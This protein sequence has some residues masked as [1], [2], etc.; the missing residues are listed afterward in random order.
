[1]PNLLAN[2][3]L[4]TAVAGAVGL[5]V[6]PATIVILT[7]Q[8]LRTRTAF[9]PT[10]LQSAPHVEPGLH[11]GSKLVGSAPDSYV[12]INYLPPSR[13]ESVRN[14]K[15]FLGMYLL[16]L[17]AHH[18]DSRQ[19]IFVESRL[20]KGINATFIDHGAMFGGPE[21]QFD[22]SR[23]VRSCKLLSLYPKVC[24]RKAINSWTTKFRENIPKALDT[25]LTR[26]PPPWFTGDIHAVFELLHLRLRDLELLIDKDPGTCAASA[27]ENLNAP[28]QV[29]RSGVGEI[30]GSS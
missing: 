22:K 13:A 12:P 5:P 15:D 1:M 29:H 23:T 30:G 2:E 17:W 10:G 18:L 24:N 6:P 14:R 26:L 3:L 21:W 27:K 19:A 11:F 7:E 25:T 16:D 28:V 9:N 8:F 4:G 20:G